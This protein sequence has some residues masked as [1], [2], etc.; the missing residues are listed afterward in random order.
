MYAGIVKSKSDHLPLAGV[1]VIVKGTTIGVETDF[2]G[3][4]SISVPDEIEVLN[5]SSVGMV[6]IEYKLKRTKVFWKFI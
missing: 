6:S 1:N 4:F 2:D 3:R 5:I